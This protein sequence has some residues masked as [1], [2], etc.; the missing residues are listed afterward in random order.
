MVTKLSTSPHDTLKTYMD[1]WKDPT[2]K[3]VASVGFRQA[4]FEI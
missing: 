1:G 2:G 3:A 4:S